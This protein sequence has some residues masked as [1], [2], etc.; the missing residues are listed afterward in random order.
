MHDF[1]YGL[2]LERYQSARSVVGFLRETAIKFAL[3]WVFY[4]G[5]A[6]T[7]PLLFVPRMWREKR[8][9]ALLFLAAAGIA[10]SSLV[11]FFNI[12]YVAPIAAVMIAVTVEG[13][14]YLRRWTWQEKP[15]GLFL[16]RALL[17]ICVLMVPFEIKQLTAPATPGTWPALGV[18]RAAMEKQLNAM[19]GDQLVLVRYGAS[20]HP[21]A[22]WVY[23]AA[24]ID[25]A[26]IVWARDMGEARN[27][28]LLR[29]YSHR[30]VWM[31]EPDQL[32]AQLQAYESSPGEEHKSAATNQASCDGCMLMSER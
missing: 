8:Q 29:Y 13:F 22:E 14:R 4:I 10:G 15:L 17:V 24:D 18:E 11:I 5:P 19:P 6:L 21:L 16:S 1:Y 25:H 30:T 12:H 23:N 27:Q 3:I 28:E 20:H 32:P 31:L 26:K 7:L 2:E 9:R